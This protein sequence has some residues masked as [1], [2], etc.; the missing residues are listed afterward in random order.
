MSTGADYPTPRWQ[1][2]TASQDD[3]MVADSSSQP[4]H[5]AFTSAGLAGLAGEA[6]CD[7]DGLIT[8]SELADYVRPRVACER[9]L[10]LVCGASCPSLAI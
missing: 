1:V 8:A 4:G 6:D 3:G 7:Q 9:P 2:L 5:S 10:P